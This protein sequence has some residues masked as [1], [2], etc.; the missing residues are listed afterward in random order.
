MEIDHELF[1]ECTRRYTE[2]QETAEQRQQARQSKWDALTEQA[3]L[4]RAAINAQPAR[5]GST[6]S[7]RVNAHP[8]LR[9]DEVD[10]ITHDSQQRLDALRLQDEGGTSKDH[11]D[12]SDRRHREHDRPAHVG[13][14]RSQ[15]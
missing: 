1:D 13:S 2:M 9:V 3:R 15:R 11:W 7:Q 5:G 4:A 8:G 14:S 6:P 10:P 12:G